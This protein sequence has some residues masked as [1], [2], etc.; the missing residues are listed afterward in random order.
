[1]A[2]ERMLAE[3]DFLLLS[4]Y[5]ILPDLP[6]DKPNRSLQAKEWWKFRCPE[7]RA[8][9]EPDNKQ[10]YAHPTEMRVTLSPVPLHPLG[11][12]SAPGY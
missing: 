8:E 6:I 7:E 3:T 12:C 10:A 1:M 11:L 5:G 9:I 4:P 2:A